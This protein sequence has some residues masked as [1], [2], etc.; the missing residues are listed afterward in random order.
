VLYIY[1]NYIFVIF[2]Q[3]N[4]DTVKVERVENVAEEDCM[5]LKTEEDWIQLVRTMKTEE[6]VSVVYWY[7][8]W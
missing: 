4:I 3:D 1:W 6:E 8:L 2:L 5:K 7:I